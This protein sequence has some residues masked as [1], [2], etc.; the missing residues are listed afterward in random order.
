MP[1]APTTHRRLTADLRA[2]GVEPGDILMAHASLRSVGPVVA[3]ADAIIRALREAVGP[4][5]TLMV[6]T[7]WEADIWD[8]DETPPELSFSVATIRSG[9]RDDVLPF[10]LAASRAARDNGALMELVRTL[11]GAVRSAN[12]GASCA[13]IGARA[14]WLTANHP[15]DYGYGEGS[16][17]DKLVAAKGKV[18]MLGCTTDHMTVLH[19]AEH[20]AKL[21]DKRIF[22]IETPLL[23]GGRTE[24]RWIEEFNTGVPVIAGPDDDYFAAIVSDFL[25]T[26]RGRTG[27]IGAAESVLVRADEIVPF[28]VE[29]LESRYGGS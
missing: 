19:H 20:L 1:E 3:G 23:V 10:D 4:D 12:P 22:R 7:D 11:P 8:V 24:F 25:V 2:L 9:T 27:R 28:A 21:P 18:L 17:F 16:P 6:Y 5:G 26:G 14:E 15:L 29:W 13:A